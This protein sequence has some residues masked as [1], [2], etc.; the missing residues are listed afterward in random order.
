[1]IKRYGYNERMADTAMTSEYPVTIR[2]LQ[3]KLWKTVKVQ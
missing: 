3:R 1:M 2:K